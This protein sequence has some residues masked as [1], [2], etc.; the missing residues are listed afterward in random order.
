MFVFRTVPKTSALRIFTTLVR[1]DGM[2]R[3]NALQKNFRG[4][5]IHFA[6]ILVRSRIFVWTLFMK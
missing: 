1:I 3:G 5:Q 6:E 2:G 4:G